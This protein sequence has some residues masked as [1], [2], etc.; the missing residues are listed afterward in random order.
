MLCV[1]VQ[2]IFIKEKKKTQQMAR[3]SSLRHQKQLNKLSIVW[4]ER[5]RNKLTF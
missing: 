3:K 1:Q 2:S 4:G 5:Q